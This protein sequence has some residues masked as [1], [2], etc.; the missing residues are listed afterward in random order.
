MGSFLAVCLQ[1]YET[2]CGSNSLGATGGGYLTGSHDELLKILEGEGSLS[3]DTQG[4]IPYMSR[5][6]E[7][8]EWRLTWGAVKGRHLLIAWSESSG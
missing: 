5:F 4:D 8:F 2:G 3:K 7:I 1:D 6:F